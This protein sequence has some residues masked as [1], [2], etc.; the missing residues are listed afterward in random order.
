MSTSSRCRSFA[1][2]YPEPPD[3]WTV[4][5]R[6]GAASRSRRTTSAARR[7]P[8]SSPGSCS[9]SSAS[10][11]RRQPATGSGSN[12]EAVAA[13]PGVPG[14]A[15]AGHPGGSRYR[16]VSAA[17]LMML[18]D[19]ERP[20]RARRACSSTRLVSPTGAA[21]HGWRR[22]RLP[23]DRR[24]T[25]DRGDPAA[26][27][28]SPR[29]S[30]PTSCTRT[31]TVRQ[32]EPAGGYES[33]CGAGLAEAAPEP[34]GR[35]ARS[36]GRRGSMRM[37]RGPTGS[38]TACQGTAGRC[39]STGRSGPPASAELVG[40]PGLDA[41]VDRGPRTHYILD[42][43]V[44]PPARVV[45]TTYDR[46]HRAAAGTVGTDRR[47]RRRPLLPLRTAHPAR[48]GMAPRPPRRRPHP[49]PRP[50]VTPSATSAPAV[51]SATPDAGHCDHG[52]R[53]PSRSPPE[54][55]RSRESRDCRSG[56]NAPPR[57]G[58]RNAATARG[59]RSA[60]K[61]SGRRFL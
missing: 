60:T 13:R 61:R 30:S 42:R 8:A 44:P 25:R 24:A 21:R 51:G 56:K 31:L 50:V 17:E 43:Q 54:P 40:K 35:L 2:D 58:E 18:S 7:S 52:H 16:R 46:K 20:G 14:C 55:G 59:E 41:I 19:P 26:E 38:S 12:A 33:C 28:R 5:L 4:E 48:P 15:A 27:R 53:D 32:A 47:R 57:A 34:R 9:S 49:L 23:P 3:G 36:T 1:L 22:A 6:A 45:A 11:R 37:P 39:G 29:R 10:G